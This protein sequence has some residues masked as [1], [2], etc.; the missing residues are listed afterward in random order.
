MDT[1]DQPRVSVVIP[2]YNQGRFLRDA[3]ESVQRQT[4]PVAELL[5]VDDGSSDETAAVAHSHDDVRYIPQRNQGAPAARNNGL[6][7][8]TGELLVFLDAD[9]RLHPHAVASAVAALD[10][11]PEWGFVSGQV[12]VV[13]VN[14][15]VLYTPAHGR[16]DA[17]DYVQ[18]LRS[19]YIW[20]PGAVMYRRAALLAVN[21]FDESAGGSAD[22]ELNL[23]IARL[24]P[25]G[26]IDDVI[27]D[28]RQHTGSMSNDV[29]YML[30]SAVTV[31]RRQETHARRLSG[32]EQA[33]R[34]GIAVV[35]EDYGGRLI[36]QMKTDVRTLGRRRR[37]VAATWYLMRYYPAGVTRLV[38]GAVRRAAARLRLTPDRHLPR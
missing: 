15:A 33:L 38:W 1:S 36:A 10:A 35:Q 34:H 37:A 7:A 5:V 28:Y 31:R 6:R 32:G 11:H 14:G 20:T 23:R 9:D 16:R 22:Y 30:K 26:C 24:F 21:G 17:Y 2:C 19:N 29:R 27:L 4:C 3:I 25:I 13:D 18:L 8:S 12:R